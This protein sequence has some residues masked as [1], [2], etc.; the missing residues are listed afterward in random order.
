MSSSR[1]FSK[2]DWQIV[3]GVTVAAL[4]LRFVNLT[5]PSGIVFDETYFA[6]FAHN[7]LT[8]TKFFDAEPPL[9]KFIIAGGEWLF[10]FNS[11]GWRVMPALFGAAVIPLMYVF[12]K[13]LFGG[14]VMPALAAGLALLDGLL[15]VE[16]RTALLDIFV[17]FFN[18]LIYVLFLASLQAATTRRSL[19]LLALTGLSFGLALAVKWITLACVG[20]IAA[21]LF[22]LWLRR[23]S[24]IK[25]LFRVRRSDAL[26]GALGIKAANLHSPLTYAVWLGLFPLMIYLAVFQIHVPFDSTGGNLAEIHRQIFHYHSTLKA[27]HPYGSAWYSWPLLIRP[28]A[29]SFE[30]VQ[31]Q[32]QVITALGNPLIW[33][34]GLLAL[35]YAF[36]RFARFRSLALLVVLVGFLAHFAPWSL[37]SRVL[38]IYHYLGGL[39]F[40]IIALAYALHQSWLAKPKDASFQL[41]CWIL[42]AVAGATLGGLLLRSWLALLPAGFAFLLGAVLVAGPIAWLALADFR[43]WRWGRKLVL[44]FMGLAA[45]TFIYFYPVWTGLSLAPTDYYRH[46][47][48][49]SWI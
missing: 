26:L 19:R 47:W 37:I 38:F 29:Y 1:T 36:W 31:G 13:R 5:H 28:V 30:T 45:V 16:S 18:L 25:R 27:N 20:T 21:A 32:W 6:N 49:R 12:V 33:W 22:I 7:Y 43:G 9:G 35:L 11:F 10:G 39:I 44:A 24:I 23:K 48:L 46:M 17:V 15:L 4:L 42:L 41:F 14:T 2:R 8:G 34:T 3:I 40:T